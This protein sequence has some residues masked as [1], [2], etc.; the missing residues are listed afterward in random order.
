[1]DLSP[2]LAA[3]W[4]GVLT[5]ISPCP[6][7]S[8][9]A[10]VFYITG[11][12]AGAAGERAVWRGLAYSLGR[13]CT[14]TVLAGLLAWQALSIPVVANFLQEHMNRVA[15]PVLILAGAVILNWL[16]LPSF[17]LSSGEGAKRLAE[18]GGIL[19]AGLLGILFALSFCPVSAALFFG[20]LI[21]LAI[22]RHSPV[23]L[24]LLYGFGTAVPVVVI[25]I[26]LAMGLDITGRL[27]A[28]TAAFE[29]W[30]R[31]ITGVVFLGAG[32]YY[33]WG[34]WISPL[35]IGD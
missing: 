26:T 15:G 35:L 21:P 18:H 32:S 29:K 17:G 10:A 16:N 6:L 5:S 25:A 12:H 14:Y 20:S 34:F 1:M 19:G 3:L 2:V 33:L 9:V 13:M 8:N 11:G 30:A 27:L 31:R 28:L 24:P 4:L 22:D 7:A 23:A